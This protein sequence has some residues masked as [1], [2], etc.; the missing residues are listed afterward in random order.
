MWICSQLCLLFHRVEATRRSKAAGFG[1][2]NTG[3]VGSGVGW[4]AQERA[5]QGVWNLQTCPARSIPTLGNA[6]RD[7]LH[8]EQS[9]AVLERAPVHARVLH[10]QPLHGDGDNALLGVILDPD[11]SPSRAVPCWGLGSGAGQHV[12]RFPLL[13][14]APGFADSPVVCD[15]VVTLDRDVARLLGRVLLGPCK[16][17]RTCAETP[18]GIPQRHP[19]PSTAIPGAAPT[20]THP[21]HTPLP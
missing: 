16:T 4:A 3:K 11:T 15:P 20:S 8:A 6:E 10:L 21:L 17:P 5:G 9:G 18:D 12:T 1:Q 13:R 19:L 7:L 2:A 14:F